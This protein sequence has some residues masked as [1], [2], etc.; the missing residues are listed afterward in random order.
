MSTS[1]SPAVILNNIP[2]SLRKNGQT[3]SDVV[4]GSKTGKEVGVA[5]W[6]I[7]TPKPAQVQDR[8]Q[9]QGRPR[10]VD[11][12][13]PTVEE[14]HGWPP[15]E[16]HPDSLQQRPW[17]GHWGGR[18]GPARPRVGVKVKTSDP[19]NRSK[20]STVKLPRSPTAVQMSTPRGPRT[21]AASTCL[22]LEPCSRIWT[23]SICRRYRFPS[24]PSQRR[25]KPLKLKRRLI[26]HLRQVTR[27]KQLL[28][29]LHLS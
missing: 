5:F 10:Q 9:T 20:I 29:L 16:T 12:D 15:S 26:L 19:P 8:V 11:Q 6:K 13:Q 27:R 17:P 4:L 22:V 24:L 14:V 3:V 21:Q 23:N 18:G 28:I 2:N 1:S 7:D 25:S